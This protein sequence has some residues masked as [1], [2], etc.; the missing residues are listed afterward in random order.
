MNSYDQFARHGRESMTTRHRQADRYRLLR[1][2]RRAQ[3]THTGHAGPGYGLRA[4][5]ARL[6]HAIARR[7]EP[8][9]ESDPAPV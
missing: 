4:H 7:L 3:R 8:T 6:L 9:P 5:L 2:A 1:A